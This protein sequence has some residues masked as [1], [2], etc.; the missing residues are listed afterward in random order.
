MG[1]SFV[2]DGALRAAMTALD[3]LSMRQQVI[4]KNIA[5]IDTPGYQAQSVSFE[6]VLQ[7]AMTAKKKLA[8]SLTSEEHLTPKATNTSFFSVSNRSG[9]SQRA[10]GNNV[11]IDVELTDLSEAGI[12]YQA[13]AQAVTKKLALLKT[14]ASR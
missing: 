4:G 9:G 12:T 7:N 3:G 8:L 6:S 10:D 11:D 2:I 13:V 5:N 14:I 1:D